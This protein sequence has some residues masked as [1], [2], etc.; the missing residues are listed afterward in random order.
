MRDTVRHTISRSLASYRSG[1]RQSWIL[2]WNGQAVLSV[3]QII[4]TRA[5]EHAIRSGKEHM[6]MLEK[7]TIV[8]YLCRSNMMIESRQTIA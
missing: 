1:S 6:D 2:Q 5:C 8:P 4:W 7:V 3:N